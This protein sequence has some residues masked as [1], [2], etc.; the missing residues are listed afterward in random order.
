M[1]EAAF[2]DETGPI[3]HLPDREVPGPARGARDVVF[4]ETA[5]NALSRFSTV[6]CG[7]MLISSNAVW[8]Q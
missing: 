1:S 4:E 8:G 7:L 5:S 6:R 3:R 2:V